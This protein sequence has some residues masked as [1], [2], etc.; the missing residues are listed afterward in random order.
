MLVLQR[1]RPSVRYSLFKR[2]VLSLGGL[3]YSSIRLRCCCGDIRCIHSARNKGSVITGVAVAC[4]RSGP[5]ACRA[6]SRSHTGFASWLAEREPTALFAACGVCRLSVVM[7]FFTM[8]PG[9]K[10]S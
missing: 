9:A 7:A 10:L 4:S 3:V 5:S 6:H 8:A 2:S 1:A